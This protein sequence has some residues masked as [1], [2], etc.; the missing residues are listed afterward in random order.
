MM[1]KLSFIFNCRLDTIIIL[2]LS[3]DSTDP[4]KHVTDVREGVL[5]VSSS[6]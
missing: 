4:S 5:M 1:F 2:C 6:E 3:L